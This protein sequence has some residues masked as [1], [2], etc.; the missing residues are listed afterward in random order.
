MAKWALVLLLFGPSAWAD[1]HFIG[2]TAEFGMYA[3]PSSIQRQGTLAKLW[4]MGDYKETQ[5]ARFPPPLL[6]TNYL[7]VKEL[8]ELDCAN[9]LHRTLRTS[10][11]AGHLAKGEPLFTVDTGA[12][13]APVAKAP[14]D[15]AQFKFGCEGGKR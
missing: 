8:K 6:W 5:A 11:F 9:G 3:D 4:V 1:W 7:S 10:I 13:F 2:K 14:L 12:A 15:I